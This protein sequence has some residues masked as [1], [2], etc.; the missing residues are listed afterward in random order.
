MKR[1]KWRDMQGRKEGLDQSPREP[2]CCVGL[3]CTV[4][5]LWARNA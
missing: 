3:S 5:M 2:R 1:E 4:V